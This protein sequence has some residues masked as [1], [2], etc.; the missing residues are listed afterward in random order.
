MASV[1][2][3]V[4]IAD[5]YKTNVCMSVGISVWCILFGSRK[6]IVNTD[7][8]YVPTLFINEHWFVNSGNK[9]ETDQGRESF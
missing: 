7:G 9:M 5:T 6:A 2:N 3:R 1:T 8:I 4:F